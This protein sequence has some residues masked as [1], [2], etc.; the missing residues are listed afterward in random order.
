MKLDELRAD[1]LN[2]GRRKQAAIAQD[3]ERTDERAAAKVG[4]LDRV[5]ASITGSAN[6]K[7]NRNGSSSQSGGN[8]RPGETGT[9]H[10][11]D[12]EPQDLGRS[13]R[14]L[15]SGTLA[16]LRRAHAPS[17]G[18]GSEAEVHAERDR[19]SGEGD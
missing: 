16:A 2:A 7:P 8:F 19:D 10:G 18:L 13:P 17:A 6:G 3:T 12:G 1:V 15:D 4:Q 14:I 5:V 9:A 11:R